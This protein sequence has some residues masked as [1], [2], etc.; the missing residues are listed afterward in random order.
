MVT[1]LIVIIVLI[2]LFPGIAKS[3]NK[4]LDSAFGCLGTLLVFAVIIYALVKF[5]S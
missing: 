5:L 2:I 3:A 1:A 4:T